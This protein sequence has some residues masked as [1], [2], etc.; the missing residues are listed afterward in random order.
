MLVERFAQ[1][2]VLHF[3]SFLQSIS[4]N[5]HTHSYTETTLGKSSPVTSLCLCFADHTECI[6]TA[7][8]IAAE[9][10][11]FVNFFCGLK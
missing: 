8:D 11:A 10:L 7:F 6:L 4:F 3:F 2:H 1:A 9:A 5:I